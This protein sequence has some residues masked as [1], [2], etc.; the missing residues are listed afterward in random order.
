[1]SFK[2]A[3]RTLRYKDPH[4]LRLGSGLLEITMIRI[5]GVVGVEVLG[6]GRHGQAA[7]VVPLE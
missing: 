3:W 5:V 4:L 2:Y 6:E 7:G 1:M